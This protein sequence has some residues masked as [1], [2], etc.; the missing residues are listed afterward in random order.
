MPKYLIVKGCYNKKIMTVMIN[1][2]AKYCQS[3]RLYTWISDIVVN[4][5]QQ[6]FSTNT[7]FLRAF[8]K[9][10]LPDWFWIQPYLFLSFY[11]AAMVNVAGL[12][13]PGIPAGSPSPLSRLP[14]RVAWSGRVAWRAL[15]RLPSRRES[16]QSTISA[17]LCHSDSG[18]S[19]PPWL[20]LCQAST[21]SNASSSLSCPRWSNL[22]RHQVE[23]PLEA[24]STFTGLS[25]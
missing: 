17:R 9:P 10:I 21:L 20:P 12:P 6:N 19:G 13:N 5:T 18:N 3:N 1:I 15:P 7:L 14:W 24:Y 23:A 22:F 11:R 8:T 25:H 2:Y 16:W 4:K